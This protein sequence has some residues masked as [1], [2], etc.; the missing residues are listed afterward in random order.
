MLRLLSLPPLTR[1]RGRPV[2]ALVGLL[3]GLLLRSPLLDQDLQAGAA[4]GRGQRKKGSHGLEIFQRCDCAKGLSC[5]VW[6]DATSS[7]KSRLHMC[8]RI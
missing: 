4:A 6:K 2:P 8:Q 3:R 5:K 1:T 7:S